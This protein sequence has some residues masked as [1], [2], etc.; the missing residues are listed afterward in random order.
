[1]W[2]CVVV[3][4]FFA[5]SSS[6]FSYFLFN[7]TCIRYWVSC[8]V[9]FALRTHVYTKSVLN[10]LQWD[11]VMCCSQSHIN[12]ITHA[13]NRIYL[14]NKNTMYMIRTRTHASTNMNMSF[15]SREQA[16]EC[17]IKSFQHTHTHVIVMV[18]NNSNTNDIYQIMKSWWWKA[19]SGMDS[20]RFN[21]DG[22]IHWHRTLFV[23]TACVCI[24]CLVLIFSRLQIDFSM[25]VQGLRSFSFRLIFISS[26]RERYFATHTHTHSPTAMLL[27]QTK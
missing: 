14:H 7:L 2:I 12:I 1:M 26:F 24:C 19:Y 13:H 10:V 20:V 22:R 16:N 23:M 6:S 9:A 4:C 25:N 15:L 17:C 18:E 5:S 27:C 21:G 3:G 8:R 11:V